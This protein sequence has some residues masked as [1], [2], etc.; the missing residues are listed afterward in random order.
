MEDIATWIAPIATTIAALMTASNLGS[1]VTGWGF[2]VFT[3]G[4]LAWLALGVMTGQ[5]NLLWQNIIL[6][7]LNL[8]G[9]WRWL[10]RQAK[11]EEGG[12]KAQAHSKTAPGE[13]LF[14][15]S[16]LTK[17]KLKAADGVEI[18]ACVDAMAGGELGML[19]YVVVTSGGVG[20]VG[21][22]VRRLEWKD[23][24]VEGESVSTN[25][26]RHAFEALEQLAKDDWR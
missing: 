8:F 10:G 16:L 22:T 18:G 21:E 25:L 24:K 23:A 7:A 11:L 12:A 1:R 5:S 13:M 14:P 3:V 2:V 26:D 19:H 17:A 6:T 15:V 20:G 4:S 9:I